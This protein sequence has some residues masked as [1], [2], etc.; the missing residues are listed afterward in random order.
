LRAVIG[1][2]VRVVIGG[3]GTRVGCRGVGWLDGW[4]VGWLVGWGEIRKCLWQEF[5]KLL[6]DAEFRS[7]R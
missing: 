1:G 5:E 6:R 4:M 2:A 7:S 3:S